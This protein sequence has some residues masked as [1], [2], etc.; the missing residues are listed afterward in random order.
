MYIFV[1]PDL[2]ATM[3]ALTKTETMKRIIFALVACI[4]AVQPAVSQ[5]SSIG[6]QFYLDQN[7][8]CTFDTGEPQIYTPPYYYEVRYVTTSNSVAV[9][10]GTLPCSFTSLAVN[11]YS[12]PATNTLVFNP[13]FSIFPQFVPGYSCSAYSNL[14][15]GTTTF[16][17]I[18]SVGHG[19]GGYNI[20]TKLYA[21]DADKDSIP[22]CTNIGNDTV[23]VTFF[24]PN[25]F[26]CS[27]QTASRTYSL[28]LDGTLFEQITS[29]S[30]SGGAA[31][32]GSF[33]MGR[34]WESHGPQ[35]SVLAFYWKMPSGISTAG[36]HTISLRSTQVY[37]HSLSVVNVD[38]SLYS[39]P[40]S[41][42]S[43]KFFNDCNNNCVYDVTDGGV[44]TGVNGLAYSTSHTVGFTPDQF[45]NYSVYFP[46]TGTFSISSSSSVPSFTACSPGSV[47]TVTSTASTLHFGYKVPN[48]LD[49][50]V[51]MWRSSAG[52]TNPGNIIPISVTPTNSAYYNCSGTLSIGGTMKVVLPSFFTYTGTSSS[53]APTVIP[54]SGGDT[55]LW[56]VANFFTFTTKHISVLIS[57]TISLNTNFTVTAMILPSAD[58]NTLNN[59]C[60]VTGLI[61]AP[62]DPNN[63]I[64][65]SAGMQPN[66][67][68]P[69]GETLYYT[70]N[71]Q[72]VGTAPAVNVKTLDTIDVN[73]D[74]ASLR[75]LQSSFPVQLQANAISRE[76]AF[77]FNGINLPDSNSNEP[78][79][80]GFVRY[81]INVKSGTPINTVIRNRAFNYFDFTA[82]VATNQTSNKIVVPGDLSAIGELTMSHVI[83]LV[84]NPVREML[85]V[86]AS[87]PVTNAQVFDLTGQLVN[88][89]AP[90]GTSFA[91][92][93]KNL[94]HGIYF[95]RVSFVD[96]STLVKR[97][98]K[99]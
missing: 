34:S 52:T 2:T 19:L 97:V 48:F 18:K 46:G 70:I 22:I 16:I 64:A 67:D 30:G 6:L 38:I 47:L 10:N 28:Y 45:G 96:G 59:V 39:V 26:T 11:N 89:A 35:S 27:A 1:L 36:T 32:S 60:I 76:V 81:S 15:Y 14:Q 79:S 24:V 88:K 77:R 23:A 43:G 69:P 68:F 94:P 41:N 5:S 25:Y 58:Q 40:C 57:P 72:N 8:N 61:G 73:L 20:N 29:I 54:A 44:G 53:P 9:T 90:D 75:I 93:M 31:T 98:V 78:G 91:I 49:P 62:F 42:V 85:M 83:A 82:P 80:H 13:S 7:N 17:P 37:S 4:V 99:Q 87:Q 21:G 65:Y 66:G 51:S 84:P 50:A 92:E 63:K 71:F 86:Y 33:G 12:V 55:L 56:S 74:L 3:P 95:V